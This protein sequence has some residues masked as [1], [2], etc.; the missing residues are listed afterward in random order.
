MIRFPED[1]AAIRAVMTGGADGSVRL[2]P[3]D[4]ATPP[5]LT[6]RRRRAL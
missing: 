1:E 5:R 4:V 6:E 2:G 3:A